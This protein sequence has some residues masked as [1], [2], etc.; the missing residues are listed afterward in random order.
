MSSK[1]AIITLIFSLV[2]GSSVFAHSGRTDSSGGHNCSEK[3]Q[4][5]GLC[6]GYHYHNGGGDT[7]ST[8]SS[9]SSSASSNQSWD[10]DCSDFSS[11]E[12]VV[13]YWN[14]KG[15]SKTNDPEKLDG[16]GNAVDD[17]IPCEAPSG[18]DT[19]Q[20]NGS[21]AQLAKVQAENDTASGEKEGYKVGLNEGSN[22][23]EQNISIEGSDAYV[24]GYT[25]G[26]QK[27]HSEGLK[28]FEAE[29]SKA[30]EAG[31]AL[32]SEQDNILVPES[33]QK[34][35]QLKSAFEEGFNSAV[36][37]R[38]EAKKIEYE[39]I[40]Y[41]NG[42]EDKL[43]EPKDVKE[44]Y[45]EAYKVGFDKGQIDLENKYMQEG[46]ESAFTTL[47]Y[48]EP[49]YENEKYVNWYKKG[50]NS[51]KEIKKI[52]DAGY[53]LGVSGEK[54]SV[55]KTYIESEVIYKHYYEKGYKEYV[56][57]KKED[58]ATATGVIGVAV[59]G[60]LARRFYVAKKMVA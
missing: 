40:G 29:K 39:E 38:D 32:G 9:S 41:K 14:S 7:S 42:L 52:Q 3:S 19:S 34:N 51:N 30:I 26:Y 45:I 48:K 44:I 15:Y 54:Y 23:N 50:F 11:Y 24:E 10:K 25:K 31:K 1:I 18:Y 35:E 55:P 13:E 59:L 6:T 22:G 28:K 58:T 47:E 8:E 16:W 17:G 12:E 56:I 49:E 5:K 43:D 4:A 20:I 27:G 53:N 21:D 36:A 57:E 46:Y 60:W 2:F 37:T 33:Y